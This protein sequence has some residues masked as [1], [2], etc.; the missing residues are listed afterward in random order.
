MGGFA[1]CIRLWL[2]RPWRRVGCIVWGEVKHRGF[3]LIADITGYTTYL[4]ESELEH[5]RETLTDLL[6]LLVEQTRPPLTVA[7]LEGDAVLSYGF[8]EGFVTAQT[9]LER[10][11]ETYV[12]FRRAIDLMVLNNT[13][14]C[15]ACAN[16]SALDLK[17][18]VH[19][20]SFAIQAVGDIRQ[21]VGSDVNLVHRLLKNSVTADTG[22]RAYLL[23]TEPAVNALDLD[24]SAEQMVTHKEA[25]PDFG[26]IAVTVK[27]MQPIY[28]ATRGLARSFYEPEDVL[29]TLS[30]DIP[31]PIELVWNY[32]NQSE[33]R[34]I[35]IGSD[36]YEVLDRKKGRVGPGSTYQ[37]HHG[38]MIVSQ[39]V[40]EWQPFE[41]V[42]LQQLIPM[43]G[44]RPTQSIID[45]QFTEID[46]GTRFSQTATKPT[47]PLLQRS[48]ARSMM[49]ARR[50]RT[51]GDME[52]FR[53]RIVEDYAS[54]HQDQETPKEL[55]YSLIGSA[56]FD[57]LEESQAEFK[58]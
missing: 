7:Q 37:C 1:G 19:Y 2:V 25:V 35:I 46:E 42:V 43:P 36:R 49:T 48:V 51:Q 40:M 11:E 39:I 30:T 15:N 18:F 10:I 38:K 52:D 14:K 4:N 23:L 55:P 27:D 24:K 56:A 47:G 31:L 12:E 9:L 3:F 32:V 44:N 53:D 29:M 16:V 57:S 54:K 50:S 22:I 26:E 34:N 21:L 45:L 41:R 5:A 17:F 6:E 58:A 20:G 8:A 33:F 28:E 13:C